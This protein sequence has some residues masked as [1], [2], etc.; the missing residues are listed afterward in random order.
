[1]WLFVCG[2]LYCLLLTHFNTRNVLSM[3]T[4]L[5]AYCEWELGIISMAFP[6]CV[7]GFQNKTMCRNPFWPLQLIPSILNVDLYNNNPLNMGMWPN[8]DIIVLRF[9][10][11]SFK[12][13][14][15]VQHNMGILHQQMLHIFRKGTCDIFIL[16]V[17]F[18]TF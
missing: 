13:I 16:I 5:T 3:D 10:N 8:W 7:T 1:V 6:V 4:N 18:M 17:F 15:R 11:Y 12:I 2:F 14:I 9:F